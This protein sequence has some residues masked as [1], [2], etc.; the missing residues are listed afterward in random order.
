[1]TDAKLSW[2]YLLLLV[3]LMSLSSSVCQ[4]WSIRP[5][6]PVVGINLAA[7]LCLF[8]WIRRDIC[9]LLIIGQCLF[10]IVCLT[11]AETLKVPLNLSTL[12][13]GTRY[14]SHLGFSLFFHVPLL[15][16]LFFVVCAFAQ[17]FFLFKIKELP[18]RKWVGG[19]ALATFAIA[20]STSFAT[21]PLKAFWPQNSISGKVSPTPPERRSLH[22]RGYLATF[23]LELATGY[24]WRMQDQTQPTESPDG[25][26]GL[27]LLTC[28]DKIV[29]IQV[30]SLDYEMLT[31]NVD[32]EYVMPFL[33]SLQ[34][35][36]VAIRL[37]G[38]K[39]MAS[40]NS[41]YE[42]FTGR[43]ASHNILHY[44]YEKDFSEALPQLLTKKVA[45]S[46][47][48]HGLPGN[49][50]NQEKTYRSQG[51]QHN[52]G[53]EKMQ[54]E[55]V[56]ITQV[57]TDG[58]VADTDLFDF[59]AQKIPHTGSFFHFIITMDMHVMDQPEKVCKNMCFSGTP[60]HVY[61]S[62]CRNTDAALASYASKLPEGTTV[63][64]WGD[65]RSYTPEG[66]G[67]IPFVLFITGQKH[68]FL[69]ESDPL[70]NRSKMYFYLKR[71]FASLLSQGC[72]LPQQ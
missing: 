16:S 50:M 43:I 28:T 67:C 65:H 18:R 22:A 63:A 72:N 1:M 70:L 19:L 58:I 6:F 40:A 12:V 5:S 10:S 26:E 71:N 48:F 14:A 51:V 35:K 32:G 21:L 7:S 47:F 52:Y 64:L 36:G 33:H 34:E 39:K 27:P 62:L 42:V 25:T 54:A 20:M 9:V 24:P 31:A 69:H 15:K 13:H 41:D 2:L 29:C 68:T 23:V 17:L 56:R 66:S 38:T 61:Y 11:V 30:E 44:E 59:A 46:Y 4:W 49:Y 8:T 37:D 57:W 53:L 45:S 55:G 3:L 60:R